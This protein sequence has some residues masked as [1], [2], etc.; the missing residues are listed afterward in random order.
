MALQRTALL[1]GSILALAVGGAGAKDFHPGDFRV[2]NAVK[3]TA[4]FDRGALKV[5]SR[6]YYGDTRVRRITAP[7]KRAPTFRLKLEGAV[8]GVAS[9]TRLDRVLVYGLN[10]GRFKRAI[11]YR[12]PDR[13]AMALRRVTFGLV[14]LRGPGRIPPSC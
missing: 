13:A 11:W 7:P 4:V 3:C 10:C 2:C 1:A 9:T 6:F 5:L 12:L 8:V 14:P